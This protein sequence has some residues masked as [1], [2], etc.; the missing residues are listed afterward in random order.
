MPDKDFQK[1]KKSYPPPFSMRLNQEERDELQKLAAG[2]PLGRF[3][4]DAIF[5]HGQ[6]PALSRKPSIVDQKLFAQLL[7]AIG[8]SRLANNINQLAK[9]ANSG[10]LPVNKEIIDSLNDAVEAI[11]WMRET[12][13]KALGLKPLNGED[14]HDFKG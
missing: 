12:L 2:L 3:I 7:G 11:K 5:N 14:S 13:I 10:S 4:K 8:K 1:S 9:A 6:R